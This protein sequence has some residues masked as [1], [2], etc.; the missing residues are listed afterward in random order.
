MSITSRSAENVAGDISS[1]IE[2]PA[3][4]ILPALTPGEYQVLLDGVAA[5]VGCCFFD[6]D[7]AAF[8][9]EVTEFLIWKC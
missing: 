4:G 6:Q 5:S 2:F 9:S 7:G 3:N 8:N 1:Y